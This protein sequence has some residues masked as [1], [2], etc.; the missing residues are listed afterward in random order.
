MNYTRAEIIKMVLFSAFVG[1][2]L[3][4]LVSSFPIGV[5]EVVYQGY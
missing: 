5:V 1:L 3:V 4:Y 2:A